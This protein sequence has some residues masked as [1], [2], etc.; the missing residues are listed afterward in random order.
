MTK[1]ATNRP[2]LEPPDSRAY[3]ATERLL[4]EGFGRWAAERGRAVDMWV[5]ELLLHYKWGWCDD[6]HLGRWTGADV[7]RLLLD[8]LPGKAIMEPAGVEA[9]VPTAKALL[10]YLADAGL[11]HRGSDPLWDLCDDLDQAEAGFRRRV[12]DPAY[13]HTG[14]RIASGMLADGVDLDDEEA[15]ERWLAGHGGGSPGFRL[16][17]VE[18]VTSAA[19]DPSLTQAAAAVAGLGRLRAFISW[20]GDGRSLTE[21]GNLRLA[22]GRELAAVLGAELPARCRSSTDIPEVDETF[23]WARAADFV[24]AGPRRVVPGP[25]A[26]LLD[27]SPPL[28]WAAAL[29]GRLRV[30]L[31]TGLVPP[32]ASAWQP[33]AAIDAR[34][35]HWLLESLAGGPITGAAF[36]ERAWADVSGEW[37]FRGERASTLARQSC[38][39]SARAA[40]AEL[41]ELGAVEIEDDQLRLSALGRF[42]V[43][44][45]ALLSE[46]VEGGA[47]E[48]DDA[49]DDFFGGLAGDLF[50][51]LD[52]EPM[53]AGELFEICADLTPG[54][55]A[56]EITGWLDERLP[57]EAAFEVGEALEASDRIADA[58]LGFSILGCLGADAARP[59]VG[60]LRGDPRFRPLATGWMV[61][62]GE[63]AEP[64]LDLTAPPDA[65]VEAL[66]SRFSS[67]DHD[68]VARAFSGA[69]PEPAQRAALESI[70]QHRTEWAA[71]VLDELGRH[72]PDRA[73]AKA[74]RKARFRLRSALSS[75]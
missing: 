37:G 66:A 26:G 2:D 28:A 15:V 64:P 36:A 6:A 33:A 34:S 27:G 75:R 5:A 44:A 48:G 70:G 12:G 24:V 49:D 55:A 39:S 38:D 63:A 60:R 73:V 43:D 52:D 21:A 69:G 42:F 30:G 72:L 13:A 47:W 1:R 67:S 25:L 35:V 45:A 71:Y 14:K 9:T 54:E 58:L 62:Q 53:G 65:L 59:V 4:L 23:R 57:A 22:D 61:G 29:V 19:G 74:A 7:D 46:D 16:E 68:E 31:L 51:L 11:L 10:E 18:A 56:S 40:I 41:V 50:G 17:G 32:G 3:E 8:L 20:L